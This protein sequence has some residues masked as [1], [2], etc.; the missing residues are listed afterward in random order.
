MA[1]LKRCSK[2]GEEKP[3][4][5]FGKRKNRGGSPQS[6]CRACDVLRASAFHRANPEKR[7][8]YKKRAVAKIGWPV[9]HVRYGRKSQLKRFYGMT[10]EDREAMLEAQGGMCAI[11]G[12]TK[13]LVIDHDH[14]TGRVRGL[15]CRHC[16]FVIGLYERYG[17]TWDAY[18]A[19][20][21]T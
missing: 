17:P 16:N 3:L 7:K 9:W 6:Q 1:V 11:C 19:G 18:L 20:V 14:K 4:D 13:E 8:V 5:Q 10:P 15:L 12:Q 2:C 21:S